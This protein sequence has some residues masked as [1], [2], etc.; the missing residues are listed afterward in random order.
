M[1]KLIKFVM[2]NLRKLLGWIFLRP[3]L[4]IKII[5]CVVRVA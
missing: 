4:E 2:V 3:S 1:D 5:K